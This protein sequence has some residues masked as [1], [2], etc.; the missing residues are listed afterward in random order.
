M[1]FKDEYQTCIEMENDHLSN[2]EIIKMTQLK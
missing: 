2:Q 1:S